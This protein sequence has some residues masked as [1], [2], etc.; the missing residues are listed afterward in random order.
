MQSTISIIGS[1]TYGEV[2]YELA[3]A[4]NYNV[5]AF[6]DDDFSKHGSKINGVPVIG[7]INMNQMP[8]AN[9]SFIVAIGENNLR[10]KISNKILELG[11]KL[12]SLVHPT[13]QI[14]P[15]A[16]LG[17]GC[18]VQANCHCLV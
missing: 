3:I 15:S 18:I 17:M 9:N 10:V 1:G 2:L 8:I 14:S 13:A 6:Y 12:P 4:L 5:I 11:G 16:Q 7:A